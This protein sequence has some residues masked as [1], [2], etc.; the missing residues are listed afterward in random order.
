MIIHSFVCITIVM[1]WFYYE[2]KSYSLRYCFAS[3]DADLKEHS[4]KRMDWH[5][6]HFHE[7]YF[8]HKLLFF[9]LLLL[10]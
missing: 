10:L 8:E 7:I 3:S 5:W 6:E 1:M 2:K 4:Y 9:R